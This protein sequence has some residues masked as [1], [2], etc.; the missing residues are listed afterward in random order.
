[1]SDHWPIEVSLC[2]TL[3]RNTNVSFVVWT[4]LS[5]QCQSSERLKDDEICGSVALQGG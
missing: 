2:N 3:S 1:M 5:L 4:I